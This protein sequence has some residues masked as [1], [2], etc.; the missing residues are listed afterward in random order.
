MRLIKIQASENQE[1]T[2]INVDHIAWFGPARDN[3]NHTLIA[4]AG[5][6]EDDSI[7]TVDI[8]PQTLIRM[9]QHDCLTI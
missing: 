2:F 8:T 3:P 1:E 5:T 7:L 6:D 4:F 9:I